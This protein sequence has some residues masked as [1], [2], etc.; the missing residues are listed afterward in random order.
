MVQIL[1]RDVSLVANN[2]ACTKPSF[3]VIVA[4]EEA[5]SPAAALRLK[6]KPNKLFL[7]DGVTEERIRVEE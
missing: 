6:I 4:A 7:F 2:P 3:K 1:G 5:E